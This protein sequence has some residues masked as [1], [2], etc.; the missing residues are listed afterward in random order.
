MD[1]CTVR[2]T[3]F[4][5]TLGQ[6]A[7]VELARWEW[8]VAQG[9]DPAAMLKSFL[10]S[11]GLPAHDLSTFLPADN[12]PHAP[13]VTGSSH[14]A[15]AQ[16]FFS[17]AGC[18]AL[19]GLP[20]GAT[21]PAPHIPDIAAVIYPL[22]AVKVTMRH[23]QTE[24]LTIGPWHASWT[25]KEHSA[26]IE[27]VK[28]AIR[29][30]SVYQANVVGHRFAQYTGDPL[31]AL[32]AIATL[33]SATYGDLMVGETWALATAT[34][35]LLLHI[36]N[37]IITTRPIKGTRPATAAGKTELLAS[38]K[39]RAEH[40]MI[41]DLMR[42]DV[43]LLAQTGTVRV[44]ELFGIRRWSDLWQAESVIQGALKPATGITEIARAL[45]P[46]GSVTGAPKRAAVEL[47]AQL[48]P[49]GRGPAMGAIGWMTPTETTLG[50]TIRTVA[51]SQGRLHVWAG[52]G[53]TIDSD[54]VAEVAEAD[55]KA[56]PLLKV[57][58][59]DY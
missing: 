4:G 2:S 7:D 1:E 56:A 33:P 5:R 13:G 53:I 6:V 38:A 16:L 32:S 43:A 14:N 41:V 45:F 39:E 50:L 11:F 26:A 30:G 40:I 18:A 23:E 28:Q 12:E 36:S 54:P 42:N 9:G 49:V 44:T 47:L 10:C 34:P 52:G 15:Q 59:G 3:V 55:A 21:S 27:S 51:A 35:E 37:G 57:L 24:P 8:H 58:A 29:R 22:T 25:H 20:V 17:A 46:G 19:A 31:T 48:E